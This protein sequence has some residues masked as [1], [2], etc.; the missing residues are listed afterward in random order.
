[1]WRSYL[2]IKTLYLPVSAFS[3]PTGVGGGGGGGE[4][5]GYRGGFLVVR[6]PLLFGGH[7][8]FVFVLFFHFLKLLNHTHCPCNCI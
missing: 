2:A 1:M 4:G 6:A 3:D 5:W 7:P 8:D